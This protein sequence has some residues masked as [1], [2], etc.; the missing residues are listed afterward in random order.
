MVVI[1]CNR[2]LLTI[3]DIFSLFPD[4]RMLKSKKDIDVVR[5]LESVIHSS[6]KPDRIRSDSGGEFSGPKMKVFQE[7][8][9]QPFCNKKSEINYVE[10]FNKTLKNKLYK[11]IYIT[12]QFQSFSPWCRG[13]SGCSNIYTGMLR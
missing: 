13:V 1:T 3:I 5:A 11:Y 10:R 2:Y 12:R 7:K 6:N 8:Q 9:Y 4:V